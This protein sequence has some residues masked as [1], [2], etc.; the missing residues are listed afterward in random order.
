MAGFS[1]RVGRLDR[2]FEDL[3]Q[4]ALKT[5]RAW[6]LKE[7][8]L[9]MLLYRYEGAALN[10]FRRWYAWASRSRLRPK[11]QWVKY[12][13]RRIPQSAEFCQCHLFPLRRSGPS[14]ML[15]DE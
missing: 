9:T 12:T 10:F 8:A 14:M 11:I 2:S 1:G 7:T 6:A 15:R 3:R 4:S 13:A 5:A